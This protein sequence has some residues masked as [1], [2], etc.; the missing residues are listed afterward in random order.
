MLEFQPSVSRWNLVVARAAWIPPPPLTAV[1]A[2]T[3]L[4]PP[5]VDDGITG[6]DDDKVEC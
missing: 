5:D 1:A 4:L 2:C 6:A 3:E